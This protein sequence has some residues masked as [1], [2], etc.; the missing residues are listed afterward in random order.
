MKLEFVIDLAP[1]PYPGETIHWA[2]AAIVGSA[3]AGLIAACIAIRPYGRGPSETRF[4]RAV[5]E[6]LGSLLAM[7]MTLAA[8]VTL[9]TNQIGLFHV[10][11]GQAGEGVELHI[12]ASI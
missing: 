12:L 1:W 2:V 6:S 11:P 4:G 9:A 3:I 7:V 10:S 8:T 5:P